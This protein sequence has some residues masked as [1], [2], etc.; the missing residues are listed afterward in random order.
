MLSRLWVLIGRLGF[1]I[2]RYPISRIVRNSHRTRVLLVCGDE[3]LV[4]KH[5]LG[6]DSWMLPGGGCHRGED[7]LAAAQREVREE[8]GLTLKATDFLPAGRHVCHD[9]PFR[10]TYDLYIVTITT[11]PDLALQRV[12][13]LSARWFNRAASLPGAACPEIAVA[14]AHWPQGA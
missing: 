2:A 4:V 14:L 1:S 7:P 12:E 10:F 11:P 8:I 3:Y 9:R 6:N 13:I 5:W